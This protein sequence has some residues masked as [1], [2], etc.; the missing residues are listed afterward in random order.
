MIIDIKKYKGLLEVFN[1]NVSIFSHVLATVVLI[2]DPRYP[3]ETN[4][5]FNRLSSTKVFEKF[6]QRFLLISE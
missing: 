6:V 2:F 3:G 5:K 4:V 1:T